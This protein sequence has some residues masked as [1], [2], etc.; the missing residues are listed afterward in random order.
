MGN[1]Q[2]ENCKCDTGDNL[3]YKESNK[4]SIGIPCKY[5]TEGIIP[6]FIWDYV[7]DEVVCICRGGDKV[8]LELVEELNDDALDKESMAMF[9]ISA[10]GYV[11]LWGRR[12]LHNIEGGWCKVRMHKIEEKA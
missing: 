4:Y 11:K 9:N 5:T 6:K 12:L 10:G 8:M 2:K 7:E 1:V 3:A